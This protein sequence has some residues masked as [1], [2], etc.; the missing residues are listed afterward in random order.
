MRRPA[1]TA[2][3]AR[4]DDLLLTTLDRTTPLATLLLGTGTIPAA[5]GAGDGGDTQ[6]DGE[7][8]VSPAGPDPTDPRRPAPPTVPGYRVEPG[9]LLPD[10]AEPGHPGRHGRLVPGV[11]RSDG[12]AV[13]IELVDLP[14]R[15]GGRFV[16]E[17]R[18]LLDLPESPHLLPVLDVGLLSPGLAGTAN[19]SVGYLVTP[20][21][22]HSLADRLADHGPPV[23]RQAVAAVTDAALGLCA[24]HGAGVL[25]G[26]L[27]PAAL[28]VLPNGRVVLG[29]YA[30]PV[31]AEDDDGPYRPPE[32]RRGGDWSLAGDIWALGAVLR[33]LHGGRP[34]DP[35]LD[36]V[37][38]EMLDDDPAQRPADAAEVVT[39]LRPAAPIDPLETSTP[40]RPV[41]TMVRGRP[42]GSGY[43]L[44]E[45]IGRGATGQ[46]WRGT[47]RADGAP[48]AVKVL[49]SE[50]ADDAEVVTRFL[51]ERTTLTGLHSPNLVPVL[52]LVAEGGTLAI[53]MEL[54]EGA[55]LRHTLAAGGLTPGEA[56]RVLAQV[57]EGLSVVHAAGLVHRD[58]KPENVLISRDAPLGDNTGDGALRA[59]LTDFGVAG[60]ISPGS[61]RR[62]THASRLVG[63][64]EYVA[65]ELAT[66][67]PAT[68]AVDVYALGVLAYEMLSG[69]RP[70]EAE[71]PAGLLRAHVEDAPVR[72]EGFSDQTWAVVSACLGKDPAGRPDAARAGAA[73][74]ALEA[75]ST[76]GPLLGALPESTAATPPPYLSPAEDGDEPLLTSD[77]T[78][79]APPAP[80]KPPGPRA[81][82]WPWVAAV[83][84]LVVVGVG[85]GLWFG[86]ADDS[87]KTTP[88]ASPSSYQG[89]ANVPVVIDSPESGSIRLR[90]PSGPSVSGVQSFFVL[91]DGTVAAQ[92]LE[93]SEADWT[94]ADLDPGTEHCWRVVAVVT[95]VR[96]V[97]SPTPLER[98]CRRADGRSD[99]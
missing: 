79:P 36:Q 56:Y 52:D 40:G 44:V 86:R 39:R 42:L 21:P 98:V 14:G 99:N 30:V 18:A 74:A 62:L 85:A 69:R 97:P 1:A 35:E 78:R 46:V 31:L 70:F 96:P 71:H 20:R 41:R 93:P 34:V 51:G 58:I 67:R 57:A 17:A 13:A 89:T 38:Q 66:G 68:G 2:R 53:V 81:R 76:G 54:V 25:H 37:L 63:T 59:R 43:L 23:A 22:E 33:D 49:R 47:R 94:A 29:G 4:T 60:A 28:L 73:F 75:S 88:S 90:F 8:P 84:A 7:E 61:G 77:A 5:G 87:P 45:P 82:R 92:N 16:D 32:V 12:M 26:A 91:R 64:P 6:V 95:S 24:L 11:R 50:L 55:D 83:L 27:S 3:R 10:A 65:P 80:P 48:V 9:L 15:R 72:P 19:G